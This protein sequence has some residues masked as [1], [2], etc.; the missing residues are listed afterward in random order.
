VHT[1][2]INI[3]GILM[4]CATTFRSKPNKKLAEAGGKLSSLPSAS[5]GFLVGLL[6]NPENGGDMFL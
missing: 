5:A 4:T 3:N 6:I 2:T 1:N